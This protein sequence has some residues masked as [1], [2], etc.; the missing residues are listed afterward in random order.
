MSDEKDL[1]GNDGESVETSADSLSSL[2]AAVS[3]NMPPP[4][5]EKVIK[6]ALKVMID[7]KKNHAS[8][9]DTVES[10]I[11]TNSEFMKTF[12]IA[13]YDL[14]GNAMAPIFIAHTDMESDALSHYLQS[15]FVSLVQRPGSQ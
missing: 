2:S 14:E 8:Y 15:Y 13:G 11:A 5:V 1:I 7:E 4:E 12:F 6:E 10:I 9:D 3:A